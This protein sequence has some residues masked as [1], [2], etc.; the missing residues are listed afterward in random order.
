[1]RANTLAF[2]AVLLL[3]PEIAA[4]QGA[5]G[6]LACV[7]DL[8]LPLYPYPGLALAA[9]IDGSIVARVKVSGKGSAE[10]TELIPEGRSKNQVVLGPAVRS[11]IDQSRFDPKCEGRT[12]DIVFHF[13][14]VGEP[15]ERPAQRYLVEAP[16]TVRI[17]SERLYTTTQP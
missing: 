2:V 12:I 6:T 5:N 14:L 3:L 4:A 15:V 10:V 17:I 11:T 9:R 16:N 8:K 13:E 1:M 7:A